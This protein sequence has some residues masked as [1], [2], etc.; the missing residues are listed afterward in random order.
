M[1]PLPC[2]HR[3]TWK[4]STG[5]EEALEPRQSWPMPQFHLLGR[6]H[7]FKAEPRW[8]RYDLV[9]ILHLPIPYKFQA[10]FPGGKRNWVLPH[11]LLS[12]LKGGAPCQAG[13]GGSPGLERREAELGTPAAG[14]GE[15]RRAVWLKRATAH[16]LWLLQCLLQPRGDN[17]NHMFKDRWFPLP[18]RSAGFETEFK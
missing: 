3:D 1:H 13:L 10:P 15:R 17:I 12:A 11:F 6:G 14:R 8:G 16:L 18:L 7:G 2:D 9:V 4:H 5:L